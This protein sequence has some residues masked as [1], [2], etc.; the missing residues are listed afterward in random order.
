MNLP[1]NKDKPANWTKNILYSI[2][3]YFPTAS[4]QTTGCAPALRMF[5]KLWILKASV[6][7]EADWYVGVIT[8]PLSK[9]NHQNTVVHSMGLLSLALNVPGL[10]AHS[11]WLCISI[12]GLQACPFKMQQWMCDSKPW[13]TETQ[14]ELKGHP[15]QPQDASS[16]TIPTQE[17][18]GML[19]LAHLAS[20]SLHG[21]I[22]TAPAHVHHCLLSRW[23]FTLLQLIAW[24]WDHILG[25]LIHICHQ[26]F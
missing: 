20:C 11:Y 24:C 22:N 5:P 2:F 3:V 14:L 15:T 9:A 12:T 10:P 19:S 18:H 1:T 4:F 21:G 17:A 23:P 16:C 26:A 8:Q 7:F 25:H 6:R 13:E